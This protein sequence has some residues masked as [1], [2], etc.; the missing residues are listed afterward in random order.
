M[1]VCVS[2]AGRRV[3]QG[4]LGIAHYFRV[5]AQESL[6][7]RSWLMLQPCI[8]LRPSDEAAFQDV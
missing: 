5:H 8:A 2:V 4:L 3:S 6:T 1:Y 7:I